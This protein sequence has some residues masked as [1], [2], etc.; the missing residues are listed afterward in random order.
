MADN[1]NLFREC[2]ITWTS[3]HTME[4]LTSRRVCKFNTVPFRSFAFSRHFIILPRFCIPHV[5]ACARN[6]RYRNLFA[7]R[8]VALLASFVRWHNAIFASSFRSRPSRKKKKR[9]E[10]KNSR[11]ASIYT[12][13]MFP[14]LKIPFRRTSSLSSSRFVHSGEKKHANF[15]ITIAINRKSR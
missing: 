15:K 11:R 10:F 3:R 4:V 1:A 2:G 6:T 9:R 13:S 7:E 5:H 14:R 8:I 12:A